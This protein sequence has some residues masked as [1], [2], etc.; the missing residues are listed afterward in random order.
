M[1]IQLTHE[2][3][4]LVSINS[5]K[6]SQIEKDAETGKGLIILDNNSLIPVTQTYEEVIAIINV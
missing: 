5:A 2:S 4:Y 6:I 3:G 1:Y